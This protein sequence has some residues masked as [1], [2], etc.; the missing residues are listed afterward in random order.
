MKKF[1]VMSSLNLPWHGLRAFP[2]VLLLAACEK[3]L[4]PPGYT[5][6]VDSSKV[7]QA[8]FSLD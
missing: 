8:S 2:F 7:P 5:L 3:K 1:F 6:L 4:Y